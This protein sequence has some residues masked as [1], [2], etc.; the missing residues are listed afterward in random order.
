MLWLFA[1]VYMEVIIFFVCR[2]FHV[3]ANGVNY[4][5]YVFKR[6]ETHWFHTS[7]LCTHSSLS[8]PT[9][10]MIFI[11]FIR[12]PSCYTCEVGRFMFDTSELIEIF[13]FP[14][15]HPPSCTLRFP[16]SHTAISVK[17]SGV[18]KCSLMQEFLLAFSPEQRDPTSHEAPTDTKNRLWRV[19]SVELLFILYEN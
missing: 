12:C 13:L 1:F 3:T 4:G 6:G 8:S 19:K 7:K 16:Q 14:G 10:R 17:D 18:Q 9:I 2:I 5:S 15:M 11:F